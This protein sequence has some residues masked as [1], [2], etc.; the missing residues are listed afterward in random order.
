M[1]DRINLSALDLCHFGIWMMLNMKLHFPL[2]DLQEIVLV[3]FFPTITFYSERIRE[4]NLR[5][6][7]TRNSYFQIEM[8][9][10]NQYSKKGAK[11]GEKRVTFRTNTVLNLSNER[12]W[13]GLVVTLA[14]Q[15]D[16]HVAYTE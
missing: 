14:L 7:Q 4:E 2:Y 1:K 3:Y 16:V 6:R 9:E 10:R 8:A 11:N 13:M 12:E 15:L 5:I